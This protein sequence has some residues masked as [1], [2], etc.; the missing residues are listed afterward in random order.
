[1]MAKYL[2]QD[3]YAVRRAKGPAYYPAQGNA[4]GKRKDVKIS[5]PTGQSFIMK[6]NGWPVGPTEI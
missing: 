5:G 3:V 4:L 1:V 6:E 2:F